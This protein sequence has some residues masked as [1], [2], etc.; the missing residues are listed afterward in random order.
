MLGI[1]SGD[2][3]QHSMDVTGMLAP[4]I[5]LQYSHNYCLTP[6]R[7]GDVADKEQNGILRETN[8]RCCS[9]CNE[10]VLQSKY[11]GRSFTPEVTV[12]HLSTGGSKG[13][14]TILYLTY[15]YSIYDQTACSN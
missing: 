6:V 4:P 8:R 5:R 7:V 14:S 15:R 12:C 1:P 2:C 9:H 13:L 11:T 3:G 10:R